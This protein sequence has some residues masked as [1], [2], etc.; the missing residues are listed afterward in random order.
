MHVFQTAGAP[1][2]YGSNIL[3]TIGWIKKSNS[4]L[5]NNVAANNNLILT[6][7]HCGLCLQI[8]RLCALRCNLYPMLQPQNSKWIEQ[9]SC[10]KPRSITPPLSNGLL[11]SVQSGFW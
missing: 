1:P 2:R 9:F 6:T 10:G 3:A 5:S 4:A 8:V 7:F 11:Y